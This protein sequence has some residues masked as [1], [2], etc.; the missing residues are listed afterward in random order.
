M[1]VQDSQLANQPV[2]QA[3]RFTNPSSATELPCRPYRH[4]ERPYCGDNRFLRNVVCPSASQAAPCRNVQ[5][6]NIKCEYFTLNTHQ[7]IKQVGG[8]QSL[9]GGR[10][11]Y[12]LEGGRKFYF[13]EGGSKI[14]FST[15]C[16]ERQWC[17]IQRI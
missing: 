11:F 17:H 4:I 8:L 12:F 5:Y 3:K 1:P 2:S 6:L 7:W 16:P 10:K 14:L 9:E 15:E 13:L